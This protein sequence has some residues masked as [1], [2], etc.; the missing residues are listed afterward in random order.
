MNSIFSI[1]GC[2]EVTDDFELAATDSRYLY[3]WTQLS[4][5]EP[6]GQCTW[7]DLVKLLCVVLSSTTL[8][9]KCA[10]QEVP[11]MSIHAFLFDLKPLVVGRVPK[12]WPKI[13]LKF[14]KN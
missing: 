6:G 4:S 7:A 9:R 8:G 5:S 10:L 1:D 13:T 11:F 14:P 3:Y 12:S 2:E